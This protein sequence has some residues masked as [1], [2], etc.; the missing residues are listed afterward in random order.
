M[1]DGQTEIPKSSSLKDHS[2]NPNIEVNP[3]QSRL[4]AQG[5]NFD[6]PQRFKETQNLPSTVQ[7]DRLTGL[8][9]E[10][11]K[12]RLQIIREF[13]EAIRIN[14]HWTVVSSDVDNLKTANNI[15]RQFGDMVIRYGA[16]RLL[17]AIDQVQ[18][19][20]NA[21]VIAMRQGNAADET[22][23]WF[24]GVSNEEI[25]KIKTAVTEADRP[26]KSNDPDFSLS[27]STTVISSA[28][29]GIQEDQE[30][31][32]K[33]LEENQGKPAF[34]F[35]RQINDMADYNVTT[36]KINKD[37]ARFPIEDFQ[38]TEDVAAAIEVIT[39]TLG[40]SRISEPLLRGILE[41]CILLGIAKI[42]P[43]RLRE[44]QEKLINI[45]GFEEMRDLFKELFG[46]SK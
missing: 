13:S 7:K 32:K 8:P 4:E 36:I 22:I 25:D 27:Q 39:N 6:I 10:N 9:V 2:E 12:L 40:G 1:T 30:V 15:S 19:S 38:A 29:S 16:T 34:D 14:R 21:R 18:L 45:N 5:I 17:Q 41:C 33:W 26:K 31:T 11:D 42:S 37:L 20:P 44:A 3:F 35:F 46:T 43:E 24:F 28:D 23:V